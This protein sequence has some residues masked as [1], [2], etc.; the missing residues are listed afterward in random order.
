[1]KKILPIIVIVI[2]VAVGSFFAGMKYGQSKNS[3][4]LSQRNFQGFE[5]LSAE[6]RQQR[7]EQMGANVGSMRL[8][9]NRD[10]GFVLGEIISRD[11]QSITV[12]MQDGG[13]KII[14]FS[15]N[16]QV[17]KFTDGNSSDLEVGE[18]VMVNGTTNQDGSI[19][20]QSIQMRPQMPNQP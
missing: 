13:S 10:S 20:A 4:N 16:T 7:I 8:I 19:T 3:D 2:I 9:G 15:D 12:K 5:N 6:E 17:S 18:T 11:N 1:M 14:F